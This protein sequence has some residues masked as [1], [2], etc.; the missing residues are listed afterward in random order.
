LNHKERV[1]EA[2]EKRG[3]AMTINVKREEKKLKKIEK[4]KELKEK[5]KPMSKAQKDILN[6]END[7]KAARQ[8]K[9]N[10]DE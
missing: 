10:E 3:G 6:I 1:K 9:E 7:I 2:K 4:D 8:L 5:S